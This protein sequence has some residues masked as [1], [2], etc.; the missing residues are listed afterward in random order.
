MAK[1]RLLDLFC[2]GGGCSVGY[3][4]AGFDCYG[5][6]N[7]PKPLKHYPFPYI[8]MDA[9]EAMDR[10]L[11]G[12]GLTFSNGETLY[13]KDFDAYHA[14][15][16]CQGYSTMTKKWGRQ[17][18]HPDLVKEVR[19]ELQ[20]LKVPYVIENVEGAPLL[21]PVMLCG[22][23]FGLGA[24]P[25][26][27]CSCG[28]IPFEYELGKYGCPN[29]C[30]DNVAKLAYKYQLRRHRLF[31]CSF[32]IVFPP[33]ACNHQGLAL[34]VYGHA[35]GQSKRDGLKFPGTDAW[36]EGMGIDWMTGNELAEA[37]PP[38]YTEYIGKY[39]MAEVLRIKG[40]LL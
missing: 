28:G 18:T 7:N 3:F 37:I 12:E 17:N 23:M 38:A 19:E 9:L 1:P 5:I 6:D 34:P 31:E 14:S 27:H 16:P 4:R 29:C 20:A 22:S 2:G 40:G 26:Y 36:R 10:L 13:L 39:L 25:E 15:P 33:A 21:N 32:G 35:G 8:C 24:I 30:G 11:R